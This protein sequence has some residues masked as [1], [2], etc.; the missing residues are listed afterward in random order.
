MSK[1]I[2]RGIGTIAGGG[3]GCLA[4]ILA[5]EIRGSIGNAIVVASSVFI[6]GNNKVQIK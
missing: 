2:N 3:L 5:D 1:G 6:F 4:A